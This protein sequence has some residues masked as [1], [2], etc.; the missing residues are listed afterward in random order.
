MA[1]SKPEKQVLNRMTN[2]P[3]SV[4]IGFAF[5][6]LRLLILPARYMFVYIT[7]KRTKCGQKVVNS[8]THIQSNLS[9]TTTEGDHEGNQ[10]L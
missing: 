2:L 4:L 9:V 10:K 5:K 7:L 1:N 6:F 8:F 3:V